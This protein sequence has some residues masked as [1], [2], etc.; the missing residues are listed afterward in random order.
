VLFAIVIFMFM[1][2][3]QK[4][5]ALNWYVSPD[6][7]LKYPEERGKT[8]FT[9]A[10]IEDNGTYTVHKIIYKSGG[11]DIYAL[12]YMPAGKE[13][14]AAL[15]DI[16]AAA[17]TKESYSAIAKDVANHGYAYLVIDQRGIGE[18]DG[19]MPSTLQD[20]NDFIS[21]KEPFQHL[22]IYDALKAFDVLR[23][24]DNIDA[25]NIVLAGE[26]MGGRTALIAGSMDSRIK[27]V[28]GYSTAGYQPIVGPAA[29]FVKSF[30]PNTYVHN[31]S[32][33]KLVMFHAKMDSVVPY[34]DAWL[35]F[36]MAREPKKFVDLPGNCN[37]GYC[38]SNMDVFFNEL[39]E[40]TK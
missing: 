39:N 36:N 10:L 15:I 14:V 6:D 23:K 34:N 26:S 9:S 13:N 30:N 16:P 31:I 38:L 19:P 29:T 21:G 22:M 25:E 7:I 40:L 35:T 12:L 11:K 32:P 5:A 24:I 4:E 2:Y 1:Q 28:I 27:A 33:R 8:E 18:T 20:Y 3:R 17:A 37:N